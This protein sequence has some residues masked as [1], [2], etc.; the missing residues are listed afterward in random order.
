MRVCG[1]GGGRLGSISWTLF[2][3]R[4]SVWS[5]RVRER[6]ADARNKGGILAPPVTRKATPDLRVSR[7]SR[8]SLDGLGKKERLLIV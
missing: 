3:F 5:E 4:F 1:G 2:F 8:V 7:I 6:R